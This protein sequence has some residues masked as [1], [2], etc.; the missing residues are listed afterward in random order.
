MK[1]DKLKKKTSS[2]SLLK[3]YTIEIDMFDMVPFL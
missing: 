3:I 1:K 2:W